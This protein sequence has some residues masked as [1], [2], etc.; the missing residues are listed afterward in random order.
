MLN[1]QKIDKISSKR[2]KGVI[3]VSIF[4]VEAH[5]HLDL[6]KRTT[7]EVVKAAAG[8]GVTKMVTVGIDL[9]SSQIALEFASRFEGVYAAIGYHPNESNLINEEGWKELE[10]LAYHKKVV[11]IGETG[12]DYYRRRSTIRQQMAA[13][14]K[15]LNLARKFDLPIIVHDRDA[16]KDIS[17][18]LKDEAIGLKVVVHCFSGDMDM[19]KECINEGYYIGIGGV[20]TFK[21]AESLQSITKDYPLDKILLETDSPFLAPHPF[22]GKPNEPKYIPLIAEKIAEIK[23]ISVEEVAKITSKT[24]QEF[25]GI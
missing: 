13:F 1:D 11:A 9:E 21:N 14:K 25:F 19:A 2:I 23:G 3:K 5:T 6:I 10:R 24:A 22:R 20:V 8:K 18:I 15:H 17:N 12:L 7:E 16:H 4:F